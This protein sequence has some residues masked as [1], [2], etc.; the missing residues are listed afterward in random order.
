MIIPIRCF[1][2]NNVLAHK[3]EDYFNRIQ[4]KYLNDGVDSFRKERFIDVKK[5]INKSYEGETL[6][7][8]GITSYCCRKNFLAHVDLTDK[9]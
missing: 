4:M 1:T 6:D 7:E 5:S 9:I 2:C 8:L 3:W